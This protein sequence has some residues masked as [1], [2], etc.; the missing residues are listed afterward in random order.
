MRTRVLMLDSGKA[1]PLTDFGASEYVVA[2]NGDV[3][4]QFTLQRH[5]VSGSRHTLVG[6]SSQG[7]EKTVQ[8][9]FPERQPSLALAQV[10]YTNRSGAPLKLRK[11]ASHAYTLKAM[12]S[13]P[14]FWSYEGASFEDRDCVAAGARL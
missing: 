4:D 1:L 12:A 6:V 14:A 10:T 13:Q 7:L 5:D 11:W 9:T 2:W 3:I 8:L